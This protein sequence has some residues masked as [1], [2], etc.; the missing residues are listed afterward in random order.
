VTGGRWRTRAPVV[1]LAATA[2]AWLLIPRPELLPVSFSRA[3][4]DRGGALLQL[5]LSRDQR[6]RLPVDLDAV[7]PLLVEA[8]LLHEDR[9]FWRHPGVNPVSLARA[10]YHTFVT[11]ERTL[12]GSTLT[13]QLARLRFGIRSR[14]PAGKLVQV[15]RALQLER[16]YGKRELLEAYLTLAPYGANIEGVAAASWI[17]FSREPADLTLDQA[18]ALAVLPQSPTRRSPQRDAEALRRARDALF[19]RYAAEHPVG[20]GERA[21]FALPL[22]FAARGDLPFRAPHFARQA[23]RELPDRARVFTTL[24]LGLQSDVETLL[25]AYVERNGRRGLANASALLVDLSSLE[26]RAQVGSAAF[27]DARIAGQVDGTL[28]KRSPGS[29]L[30]PFVYALALDAGLIHPRSM[31]ED[32]PHSFG[33]FNPENFDGDFRGPLPATT[34]LVMSRNVPAVTLAAKLG[35]HDLHDL[36]VRAGVAGLRERDFYGL[37]GVLGGV[38]LSMQEL[39]GLYAMLGNG[40]VLRGLR[41]TRQAGEGARVRLVGR[42]ASLLTLRMLAA[43]PRP[44]TAL[45]SRYVAPRVPVAWK[46]GTSHGFRDAWAVGLFGP[47][48]LAVWVGNF[49]GRGDPALVGR[50]AAG[51]LFFEIADAIAERQ[52]IRENLWEA[53]AAGPGLRRVEVCAI[54]GGLPGPHCPHRAHTWFIPGR[55]PIAGCGVHRAVEVEVATGLRACA[56]RPVPTRTEVHEFWSSDLRRLFARAGLPRR[57][58]PQLHPDCPMDPVAGH[59]VAPRITSPRADLVYSLRAGAGGPAQIAFSAVADG[60]A[61]ELYWFLDGKLLGSSDSTGPF[62]WA[63]QPGR[64]TVRAVDGFGRSAALPILVEVVQ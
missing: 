64:F 4:F 35:E 1:A 40:G 42:E 50:D 25:R 19:A 34:A 54:S 60:D 46:T 43:N 14:T 58:P 22:D 27:F 16:H 2:L 31:L 21:A 55:S 11:G 20:A 52:G 32:A 37:A 56:A 13:M 47:Y 57:L 12:G 15:A 8:T 53:A 63:A 26:V 38:E 30:K 28:A 39:T 49:D 62:Y 36:L 41:R 24:D 9:H 48:V 7:S 51:P 10:A 61:R 17:Y 29:A 3:V 44:E 18:L 45:A 33:S 5:T 59:G 23:L 6:Y